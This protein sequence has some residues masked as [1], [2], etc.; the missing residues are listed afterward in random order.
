MDLFL[1]VPDHV[2]VVRADRRGLRPVRMVDKL[3]T[4]IA[5]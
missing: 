3:C 1:V 5:A 2:G 4:G